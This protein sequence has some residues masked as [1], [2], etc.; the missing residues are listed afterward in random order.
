MAADET[1]PCPPLPELE[2]FA[3]GGV[4]GEGVAAHVLM[5]LGLKLDDVR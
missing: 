3:A 4:P 1:I 2:E 5:N